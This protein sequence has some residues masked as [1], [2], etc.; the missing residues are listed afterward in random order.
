MTK[1]QLIDKVEQQKDEIDI[2][3]RKLENETAEVKI[4]KAK[5]EQTEVVLKNTKKMDQIKYY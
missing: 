5:A 1:A 4:L 3:K 2:A